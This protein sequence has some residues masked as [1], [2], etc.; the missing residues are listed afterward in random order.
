MHQLGPMHISLWLAPLMTLLR[1]GMRELFFWARV[2]GAAMHSRNST[3]D[4]AVHWRVRED[5]NLSAHSIGQVRLLQVRMAQERGGFKEYHREAIRFVFTGDWVVECPCCYQLYGPCEGS[6]VSLLA[7][8][9]R[10]LNAAAGAL[11]EES[12]RL[13]KQ[14]FLCAKCLDDVVLISET[15]AFP[16]YVGNAHSHVIPEYQADTHII[17]LE[18]QLRQRFEVLLSN[19]RK[20]FSFEKYAMTSPFRAAIR[21]QTSHNNPVTMTYI[22]YYREQE[23]VGAWVKHGRPEHYPEE[24]ETVTTSHKR[25][26]RHIEDSNS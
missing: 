5:R 3:L 23:M 8:D 14:H 11:D 26:V 20:T 21:K 1:F 17:L 4:D 9:F 6:R 19:A 15:L 10:A 24:S 12:R 18:E 22:D 16:I 7:T 2:H 13:S 25:K